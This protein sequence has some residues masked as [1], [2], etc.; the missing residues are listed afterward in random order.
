MIIFN[1]KPVYDLAGQQTDP[2]AEEVLAICFTDAPERASVRPK[3]S[4][5]HQQWLARPHEQASSRGWLSFAQPLVADTIT[6]L[7]ERYESAL[8]AALVPLNASSVDVTIT[9]TAVNELTLRWVINRSDGA[10]TD[11]AVVLPQGGG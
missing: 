10:V 9:Q 5:R 8:R 4:R 6:L 2:L 3:N 7:E 1:P 11:G